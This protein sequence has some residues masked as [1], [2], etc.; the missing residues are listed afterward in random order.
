MNFYSIIAIAPIHRQVCRYQTIKPVLVIVDCK[1]TANSE[2]RNN[3]KKT[4]E[5]IRNRRD[6]KMFH[7][8]CEPSLQK[9]RHNEQQ[10]AFVSWH[11][12]TRRHSLH[13]WFVFTNL[14]NA[15]FYCELEY[16]LAQQ[17]NGI[18]GNRISAML[19]G[20]DATQHFYQMLFEPSEVEC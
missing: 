18:T 11:I 17:P 1:K 6:T 14:N 16:I 9:N 15:G 19:S 2:R 20:A 13:N 5:H 8:R 7:T 12:A 10:S 4:T 3:N